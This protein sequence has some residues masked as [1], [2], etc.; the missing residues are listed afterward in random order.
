MI[1]ECPTALHGVVHKF[2]S[3]GSLTQKDKDLSIGGTCSLLR[4]EVEVDLDLTSN[5]SKKKGSFVTPDIQ[6]FDP[7]DKASKDPTM[8]WEVGVS[9]ELTDL[10]KKVSF[11]LSLLCAGIV[12]FRYHKDRSLRAVNFYFWDV[13]SSGKEAPAGDYQTNRPEPVSPK[14]KGQTRYRVVR[15]DG[16]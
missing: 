1:I 6:F 2:L 8:V 15:E 4:C 9:Q 13:S 5:L 11:I 3:G 14:A 16:S 7:N 10:E 12:K